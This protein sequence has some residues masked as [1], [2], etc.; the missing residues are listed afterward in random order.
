MNG[1]LKKY[2][3]SWMALVVFVALQ[4]AMTEVPLDG[5]SRTVA[6]LLAWLMVALVAGLLMTW[7]RAPALAALFALS[8]IF[9]TVVL[10]SI[11]AGNDIGW[12]TLP[13]HQERM[14]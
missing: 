13:T 8:G 10:F 9:W 5:V 12:S 2:L 6:L 14:P 1:T 3:L 11:G 7:H 4:A